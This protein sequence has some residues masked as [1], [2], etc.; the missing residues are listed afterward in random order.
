[1]LIICCCYLMAQQIEND[2]PLSREQLLQD[3]D[4]F[5]CQLEEIHPDPYSAFGGKECFSEKVM[6]LRKR[7]AMEDSLSLNEM[8]AEVTRLLSVL[9]D[10]HTYFGLHA[11]HPT[12][13]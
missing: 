8:E 11:R 1:M 6:H 13:I 5:F 7:L 12:Q 4:Y 10:G 9:H 2:C 3:Y